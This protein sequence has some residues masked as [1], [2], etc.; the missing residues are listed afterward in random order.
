LWSSGFRCYVTIVCSKPNALAL[1]DEW[2]RDSKGFAVATMLQVSPSEAITQIVTEYD[3]T[4]PEERHVI[5]VRDTDGNL[6][7][8]TSRTS[9]SPS[10]PF[11]AFTR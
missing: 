2:V 3:S 9:M 4:Y 6:R 10:V 5:R 8:W 11:L 1:V 7:N